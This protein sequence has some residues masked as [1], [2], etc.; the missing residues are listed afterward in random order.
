MGLQIIEPSSASPEL[1]ILL[2]GPPG[3]GKTTGACSAPGPVLVLNAESG[4]PL[5]FARSM[6]GNDRIREVKV[7]GRGTM[8]DA[9]LYLRDGGN[10]E[11]TVVVDSLGELYRVVLEEITKGGKPTLPNYGDATTA[12]ERFCRSLLDLPVNV[13]LIAHEATIK[14]EEAGHFERLPVAGTS[15]PALGVKLMAMVDVVGY[16]GRIEAAREDEKDRFVA[17]MVSGNGRR[18]KDR[19]GALGT[20]ADLDLELW[21][22]TAAKALKPKQD[23]R[24]K[25]APKA[26]KDNGKPDEAKETVKT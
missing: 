12:V 10:G 18:G 3:C 15:N 9:Y 25:A 20:Y 21:V 17:Q 22:H 11:Q 7:T 19:T 1:A 6:Y 5:R 16:C 13:V 2:Y 24:S 26:V 23:K 8:E 4:N 14:D